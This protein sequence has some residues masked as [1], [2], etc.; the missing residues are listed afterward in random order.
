VPPQRAEVDQ[1]DPK[2]QVIGCGALVRELRATLPPGVAV[3]YLPAPLHNQPDRIV[4]AIEQEVS[5]LPAD[6]DHVFIAYG[7]CG[8][9]GG[10]DRAIEQWRLRHGPT[11]QRLPGDHC[12]EFLAGAGSAFAELHETEL[13]TLF[14][15][16]Y[17]ARHFDLL[18]WRGLGLAEHPELIPLY[19]ANYTRLVHLSQTDDP[20]TLAELDSMAKNAASR[21][22]L[23]HEHHPTGLGPLAAAV[24]IGLQ[25]AATSESVR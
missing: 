15:T 21:L 11:F 24:E 19:F 10:L 13:G 4:P 25:P 8:T 17:L 18:I 22:G 14:L 9:G 12:Y 16:D 1:F 5:S 7:D 2:V 23:R 6:V 20:T 3:T